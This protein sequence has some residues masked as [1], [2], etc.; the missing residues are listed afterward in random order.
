MSV[1]S[2]VSVSGVIDTTV[3]VLG[4]EIDEKDF[5]SCV[6]SELPV[7]C[8]KQSKTIPVLAL[9]PRLKQRQSIREFARPGSHH[10]VI[11]IFYILNPTFDHSILLD[12]ALIVLRLPNQRSV[13]HILPRRIRSVLH[14]GTPNTGAARISY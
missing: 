11:Y 1:P 14:E 7:V 10:S 3:R 12:R 6:Y 2:D 8:N 13:A 9:Y 4:E 5:L